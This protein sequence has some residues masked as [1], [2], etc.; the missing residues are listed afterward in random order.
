V[1]EYIEN[2][3]GAASDSE[4]EDETAK[5]ELPDRYI[6]IGNAK[7][8]KCAIKLIEI[9]PRLT[10]ELFK[11]ERGLTEGDILYHKYQT[12]TP[13]EA[14]AIKIRIETEKKIVSFL[15]SKLIYLILTSIYVL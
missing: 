7:S 10:L 8:Q 4:A 12:K 5:V 9:G 1:S 14:E 11:V 2:D 3:M 15:M 13:E 6:G